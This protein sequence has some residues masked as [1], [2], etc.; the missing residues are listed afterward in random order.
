MLNKLFKKLASVTVLGVVFLP[1]QFVHASTFSVDAANKIVNNVLSAKSATFSANADVETKSAEDTQ[2]IAMH[3]DVDGAVDRAQNS[4]LNLGFFS[5]DQDGKFQKNTAS[6]ITMANTMYFCENGGQWYFTKYSTANQAQTE[7]ALA[8]GATEFTAGL[9]DMFDAGVIDSSMV[10]TEVV[11]KT[12]T[13]RYAYAVNTD[14]LTDFLVSKNAISADDADEFSD[15]FGDVSIGGNFWVDPVAMLPVMF[16]TNIHSQSDETAYTN[17]HI[18]VLFKS[19]NQP[20]K[21][22]EPKHAIDIKNYHAGAFEGMF[23]AGVN[24]AASKKDS[25]A[26]G[27]TDYAEKHIWHSNPFSTDTDSDGYLDNT[28]VINGYNPNGIGKL[29]S[30]GD[31]LTDYAEMTIHWTNRYDS[32]SDDDGYND[33]LEIANGYDPNGLGKW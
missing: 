1:A 29:D 27:L 22:V 11:N 6:I 14:K 2:P 16:T 3:L 33:G 9:Q 8:Q 19:F 26:D 31:G 5:T 7:E 12:M 23:H 28:E 30:D 18:S 4:V 32:D 13:V 17:L 10:G 20:V 21:I 15:S 24:N 25:D